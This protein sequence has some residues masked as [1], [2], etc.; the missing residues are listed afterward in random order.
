MAV[1]VE[2]LAGPEHEDAKEVGA[3]YEGDDE[4]EGED[5]RVL[6][7]PSGDHGVFGE[8]GFP[9]AKGDQ[10]ESTQN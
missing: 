7:E 10:E 6:L 9:D 4:G 2:G 3:G 5:S 1:N 8:L